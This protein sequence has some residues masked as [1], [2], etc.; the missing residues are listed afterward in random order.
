MASGDGKR[1][2]DGFYPSSVMQLSIPQRDPTVFAWQQRYCN[3]NSASILSSCLN[4]ENAQN[5]HLTPV[6]DFCVSLFFF[7]PPKCTLRKFFDLQPPGPDFSFTHSLQ[8]LCFS[9]ASRLRNKW[10]KKKC[11]ELSNLLT[12]H[13]SRSLL[14]F[15]RRVSVY[16]IFCG[17]C[18]LS[19]Y[20]T[21]S[22]WTKFDAAFR[23]IPLTWV[24]R[25]VYPAK[26]RGL[27]VTEVKSYFSI[28][29]EFL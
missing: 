20:V 2:K 16:H 8:S 24:A 15:L 4:L 3:D 27:P 25:G 28:I 7:S 22:I 12:K 14:R 13:P 9:T 23:S 11:C 26:T 18:F 21:S 6:S 29:I 10:W 1:I 17:H 5:C 19:N